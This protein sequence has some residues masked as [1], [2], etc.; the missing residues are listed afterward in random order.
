MVPRLCAA[1]LALILAACDETAPAGDDAAVGDLGARVDGPFDAARAPADRAMDL[2]SDDL[3]GADSSGVDLRGSDLA[4]VD[5]ASADAADGAVPA[6]SYSTNFSGVENPLSEGG[7]WTEG[8]VTGIDWQNVAK[9]N[10]LAYASATSAG[11]NDCIA[12]VSGCAADQ[13]AQATVHA[14]NGYNPKSSH[15][16]E[17]LLRFK[18]T[19]KNARGYEINC[20]WGGAY[21]QI[22]RWNGALNDFTYLN[23]QGPGF[24]TLVEGDVIKAT[25]IGS[26]ITVYKNGQQVMQ[27][28]DATWADGNPGAGFFVRPDASAVPK[29]Y[30]F[31]AFSGGPA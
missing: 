27:V 12:H 3:A 21:S 13:F 10:G 20:G 25:A 30:C 2:T 4:S 14:V 17:L 28:M 19:N 7:V 5:L 8:G 26:T 22:V 16:V 1:A 23:P 24:G 18:I 29:S 31:S 11:F 15:E 6:C 9:D